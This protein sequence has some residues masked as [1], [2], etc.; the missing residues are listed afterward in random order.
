M[1][2]YTT[3]EKV[4]REAG[5]SGNTNIDEATITAAL[6]AAHAV[7]V[8]I[9]SQHYTLPLSFVPESL[10][11]IEARLAA[12]YLLQDEYGEQAEGT[13]KEGDKKV[14]WAMKQLDYI[15]D[16]TV[17][18]L[19]SNGVGLARNQSA[20]MEGYPLVSDVDDEVAGERKFSIDMEF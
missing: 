15:A 7:V 20:G 2:A 17:Q 13:S 5:F 16:G 1:E 3:N 10:K 18:L 12:G 9:V 11:L 8:G 6:D 4:R 19:D 14:K